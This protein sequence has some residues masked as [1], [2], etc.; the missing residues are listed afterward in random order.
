MS[1]RSG[2]SWVITPSQ[3]IAIPLG[4]RSRGIRSALNGL[5]SSHAARA[6]A[7]AKMRAGWNDRTTH[8]RGSLYGRSEGT[9][10]EIGTAND[11]Y[12][13]YL[14]LGTSKM[15]SYPAIQEQAAE[16]AP[17]YFTDAG[18]LVARMIGGGS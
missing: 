15:R 2:A 5:A 11:E 16:T 3:G 18:T 8:A 14:E 6:E 12:G 9:D 13:V 1:N 4:E 7:G 17:A 10:I